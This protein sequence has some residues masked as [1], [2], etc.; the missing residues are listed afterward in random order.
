[1]LSLFPAALAKHPY[2]SLLSGDWKLQNALLLWLAQETRLAKEA[3][4]T[5]EI[6]II[7]APANR[8]MGQSRRR[9]AACALWSFWHANMRSAAMQLI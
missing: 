5:A 6:A 7:G 2:P 8:H 1:M 9:R 3:G 4:Q